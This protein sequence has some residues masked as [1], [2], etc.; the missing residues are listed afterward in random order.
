MGKVER[1]V[2]V[3]APPEEVFA[4]LK[5]LE[6]MPEY[7]PSIKEHKILSEGPIGNG[8][9]TRCVSEPQEGRE[10]IYDSG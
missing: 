10:M 1:T 2:E 5:D 7:M 6:K 3:D 8:T 4:Y 9:K